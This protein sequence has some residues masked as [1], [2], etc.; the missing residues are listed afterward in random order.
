MADD[1]KAV[2]SSRILDTLVTALRHAGLPA[3]PE[4]VAF[5][6]GVIPDSGEVKV[7]AGYPA[8]GHH[9]SPDMGDIPLDVAFKFKV[10]EILLS[11]LDAGS[12]YKFLSTRETTQSEALFEKKLS[13]K[14]T[15]G[16]YR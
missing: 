13:E 6:V 10:M 15:E 12:L 9:T 5:I 16:L 4:R 7:I 2:A 8:Q 1:E 11:T 14:E 3:D